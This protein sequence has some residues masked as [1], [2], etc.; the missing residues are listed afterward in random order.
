[1][2][3]GGGVGGILQAGQGSASAPP[4]KLWGLSSN[5]LGC[6]NLRCGHSLPKC[7]TS[8]LPKAEQK[9]ERSNLKTGVR[10]DGG[11]TPTRARLSRG[12]AG[13]LVCQVGKSAE[14]RPV[15]SAASSACGQVPLPR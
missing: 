4:Q 9:G 13:P 5:L 7:K 12:R 14:A 3:R 15:P 2:G 10:Q 1:M 6:Q 11:E 8:F